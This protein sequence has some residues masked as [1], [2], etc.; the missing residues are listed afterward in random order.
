MPRPGYLERL[1]EECSRRGIILIFDEIVTGFRV[2]P[3]GAQELFQVV[4]DLAVYSK[5]VG[6]GLPISV[7]AGRRTIMDRIAEND[8]RHGG[9]YN[10]NPLCAASALFTLQTIATGDPCAHI[11]AAGSQ[12]MDAIRAA[13]ARWQVPCTVQ[14]MGAMFQVVFGLDGKKP[15]HYRD[16]FGADLQRFATFRQALLEQG[17]HVNNSGMACWFLS[18]AHQ[19]ADIELTAAAIEEAMRTIHG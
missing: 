16:L 14:G 9:T 12:L 15:T 11:N 2:A 17:I 4:P 5:A 7:L 18:T 8:I 10:G 3:G 6:G 19:P 13:A 1:R